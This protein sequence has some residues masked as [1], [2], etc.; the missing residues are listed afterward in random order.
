M[1]SI[2]L[3]LSSTL[4]TTL[5]LDCKDNI[6]LSSSLTFAATP[7]FDFED[8]VERLPPHIV[9]RSKQTLSPQS[10]RLQWQTHERPLTPL[11]H[12]Q[13][14][15]QTTL[16]RQTFRPTTHLLDVTHNARHSLDLRTD[17]A[18]CGNNDKGTL[19]RARVTFG[20][21]AWHTTCTSTHHSDYAQR[22][23]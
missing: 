17:F 21:F 12:P 19:T 22:F 20:D 15:G 14:T 18:T 1:T 3:S 7:C 13:Q 4:T 11:R 6:D 16:Q 8:L 9:T 2:S 10:Q 5:C 23:G